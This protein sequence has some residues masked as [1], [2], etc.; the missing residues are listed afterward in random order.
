[1]IW[2]LVLSCQIQDDLSLYYNMVAVNGKNMDPNARKSVQNTR[3]AN[4]LQVRGSSPSHCRPPKVPGLRKGTWGC[5]SMPR[6]C[7]MLPRSAPQASDAP[8][9][10]EGVKLIPVKRYS[11]LK[12]FSNKI[13]H[14][15]CRST[16]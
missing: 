2:E 6:T 1:M 12:F 13:L 11:T 14:F 10:H 4:Q 8:H 15:R 3:T 7:G 16:I 5:P 9:L